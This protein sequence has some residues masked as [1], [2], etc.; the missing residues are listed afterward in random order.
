MTRLQAENRFQ[1]HKVRLK[2]QEFLFPYREDKFQF[3]KVR[4][5]ARQLNFLITRTWFQ[6]HKVRLKGFR[7]MP[8]FRF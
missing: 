4:L 3:H 8:Q 6:F 5:K 1:F 2:E 7:Q